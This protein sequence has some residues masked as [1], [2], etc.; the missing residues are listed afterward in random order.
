MDLSAK[1]TGI[2]YKPFLCADLK[3]F[4]FRELGKVLSKHAS[5]VLNVSR[6]CKN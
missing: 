4:A 6:R 5:F 2:K 1:I 3:E